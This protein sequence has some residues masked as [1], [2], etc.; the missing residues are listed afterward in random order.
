MSII[1]K[2]SAAHKSYIPNNAR[3]N[4]YILAE[5]SVTDELLQRFST[6]PSLLREYK[7]ENFYDFYQTLSTVLFDL[8]ELFEVENCQFIANDKLARVRF[9][10]ELHQWQTN[11]QI[12]FYYDPENHQLQ[13]TFF[14]ANKRAKK[15]SLLFLTSGQNIR[16]NAA[17]FHAKISQLVRAY[18]KEL[19]LDENTIRLR[20]HQ[21]I[22]YDLFAKNKPNNKDKTLTTQA[23][24]LRPIKK[25]YE[26]Q[27]VTLPEHHSAMTYAVVNIPI[28][29]RL[30][31]MVEVDRFSNDPYNP[32]YTYLTEAF[33]QA[34]KQYNLN[35]G[36][37]IANG[38]VPIVRYSIHDIVSRIG[39]LQMLGY[40]PEQNPCG[41]V[42]K[43]D[44]SE[45]VDNVKLIFVATDK[46]KTEHGFGRFLNQIEQTLKLMATELEME[47]IKEEV[48]VRFH[49]HVA[50][51]Y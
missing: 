5:F 46:N 47:P 38:L 51:N 44:A 42:S 31:N 27:Q 16:E 13:K 3:D 43:W 33:T 15:I 49:Q 19:S 2:R 36:A 14:D 48:L 25:R 9:G 4:Q 37:L 22:T 17:C 29:N 32:L 6:K 11:Q 1:R 41:I 26:S 45:L 7:Q 39:E 23:H 40:N 12:L 30:L 35:N 20:D 18:A 34:S 8:S 50:Y 28:S 10:Q 24:K 21:H